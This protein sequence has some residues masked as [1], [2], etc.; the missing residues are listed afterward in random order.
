[1]AYVAKELL[2]RGHAEN[3][4]NTYQGWTRNPRMRATLD[5]M[6]ATYLANRGDNSLRV[7]PDGTYVPVAERPLA[8][9]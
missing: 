2:V 6:I 3:S 8:D 7:N 4:L 5:V 1:M 9:Y